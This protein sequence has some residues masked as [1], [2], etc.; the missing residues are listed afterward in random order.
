MY[1]IRGKVRPVLAAAMTQYSHAGVFLDHVVFSIC[2]LPTFVHT[3]LRNKNPK[4][5]I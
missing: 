2:G 5:G 1:K 4:G 3:I